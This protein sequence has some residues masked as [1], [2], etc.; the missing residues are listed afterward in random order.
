MK[1]IKSFFV[2]VL[3]LNL[4]SCAHNSG[5]SNYRE[6]AGTQSCL[7]LTSDILRN[8]SQET[9]DRLSEAGSVLS[10][11]LSQAEKEAV[12]KAHEVGLREMGLSGAPAGIYNYNLRQLLQKTRILH[13]AGFSSVEIRQ[14]M[15]KKIVGHVT[16]EQ[17]RAAMMAEDLEPSQTVSI[18]S[19]GSIEQYSALD[20]PAMVGKKILVNFFDDRFAPGSSDA[21]YPVPQLI[22][23]KEFLDPTSQQVLST[24]KHESISGHQ[25]FEEV[26]AWVVYTDRG[27]YQS[28]TFTSHDPFAIQNGPVLESFDEVYQRIQQAEGYGVKL[29]DIE[30][31]HTHWE[32]G[33]AFS[34]GDLDFQ[35]RY[36]AS[37]F[38][39]LL[40]H[41]GSYS[42]YAIPVQGEVLFRNTIK[43]NQ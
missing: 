41:G 28:R 43:K 39:N 18:R 19:S 34:F 37:K 16:P 6:L 10:K 30:F 2:I 33:E 3:F 8:Q 36:Y 23:T 42:S 9:H 21:R 15:E 26:G 31:Y 32:R 24:I 38:K 35:Q 22:L 25:R 13:K 1:L 27:A 4:N 14:L 40:A 7:E 12:I 20:S 5:Q 17:I 29:V 11:K